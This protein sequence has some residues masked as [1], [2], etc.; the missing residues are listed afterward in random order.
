VPDGMVAEIVPFETEVREP[1]FNAFEKCPDESLSCAVKIFPAV[2]VPLFVYETLTLAPEQN[3]P[4][5]L[6]VEIVCELEDEKL[7]K[8]EYI[9]D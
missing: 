7:R 2:N 1:M 6:P 4:V 8:L 3:G 9:G 5:T